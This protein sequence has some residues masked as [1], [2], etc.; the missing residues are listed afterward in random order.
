MKWANNWM[1][2]RMTLKGLNNKTFMYSH[3]VLSNSP[4]FCICFPTCWCNIFMLRYKYRKYS[5]DV[6]KFMGDFHITVLVQMIISCLS[7][8]S[9]MIY[10]RYT[11]CF[12]H[13]TSTLFALLKN[14]PSIYKLSV[15][16]DSCKVWSKL[17]KQVV[18]CTNQGIS[19]VTCHFY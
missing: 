13:P 18:F 11:A 14:N 4:S 2:K 5:D 10:S 6:L 12:L 15:L 17:H 1:F 8:F 16:G 19:L 7:F 3:E 9:T